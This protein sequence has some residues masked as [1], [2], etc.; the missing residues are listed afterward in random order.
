VESPI[1]GPLAPD[2]TLIET[3]GWRN[4][5][6]VNLRE[7]L[8]RLMRTAQALGIRYDRAA[9]ERELARHAGGERPLRV[10]L[11][12]AIDGTVAVEAAP[13]APGPEVWRLRIAE[14]R[15]ESADPW[16]RLKTSRRARYDRA[17]AALPPG[18]D[19]VIFRN[20]RG[21]LCEGTIFNLFLKVGG[22]YLT[23]PE[24]CGLLPGV[25]RGILLRRG[26]AQ[27]AVLRPEDLARGELFVGNSL[28]GLCPA[29]LA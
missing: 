6:F 12:I 21:E 4:A 28:R 22:I 15:L 18:V 23:P 9:I 3:F 24:A 19:E 14:E 20:E 5:G 2:L 13:L 29:R 8:A 25:Q 7:H 17:R 16:L 11:T 1:R 27:P 10:R 26:R